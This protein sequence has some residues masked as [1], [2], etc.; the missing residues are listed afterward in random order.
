[1]LPTYAAILVLYTPLFYG[2]V[3]PSLRLV[4]LGIFSGTTLALPIVSIYLLKS[5][6][7]IQTLT[8]RSR[9]ERLLPMWVSV[10]LYAGAWIA[11]NKLLPTE[12]AV[13]LAGFTA[14]AAVA[15]AVTHFYKISAHA[16]AICGFVG[17]WAAIAF[18]TMDTLYL[19]PLLVTLQLA[20]GLVWARLY[21]IA[22][23][24]YQLA[25]GALVGLT[26]G[27]ITG[28]FFLDF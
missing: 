1:V 23:T 17:V 11:L 5:L 18:Q 9:T 13:L 21:L 25:W 3:A 19:I 20:G 16:I 24:P 26:G 10:A 22:H 4:L 6:G 8:M 7:I 27:F 15:T 2:N 14:L 28:Y 12:L